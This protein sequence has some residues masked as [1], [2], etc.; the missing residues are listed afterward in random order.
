MIATLVVLV[1]MN[2]DPLMSLIGGTRPGE[3]T[4]D[5][6][7]A[8]S[9]ALHGLFPALAL[10]ASRFPSLAALLATWLEPVTQVLRR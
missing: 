3:L 10:A 2:R 1:Q 7:F 9:L 8:A 5:R 6:S 4:I